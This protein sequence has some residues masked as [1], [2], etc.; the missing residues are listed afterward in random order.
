[1]GDLLR[2]VEVVLSF[3][4]SAKPSFYFLE[5]GQLLHVLLPQRG[6][7]FGIIV[8]GLDHRPFEIWVGCKFLTSLIYICLI[9]F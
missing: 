7:G 9:F 2:D 5:T 3:E 8:G 1:M 6:L 4:D